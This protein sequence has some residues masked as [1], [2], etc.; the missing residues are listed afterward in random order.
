MINSYQSRASVERFRPITFRD[1]TLP[2]LWE[3][4]AQCHLKGISQ[5]LN[6]IR[7][8]KENRAGKLLTHSYFRLFEG[9]CD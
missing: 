8:G 4:G 9:H 5:V 7:G 3:M 2:L 6:E 1:K